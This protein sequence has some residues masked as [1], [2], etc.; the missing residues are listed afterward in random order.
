MWKILGVVVWVVK[1]KE[2]LPFPKEFI[3]YKAYFVLKI[4]LLLTMFS[5]FERKTAIKDSAF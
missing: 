5:N 1:M 4:E 3:L 2:H